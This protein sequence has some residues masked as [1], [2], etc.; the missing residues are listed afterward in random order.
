MAQK[1]DRSIK[2]F[3]LVECHKLVEANNPLSIGVALRDH[4][5]DLS[6]GDL[7]VEFLGGGHEVFGRDEALVI[8]IEILEDTLDILLSVRLARPLGHQLHEFLKGDL[9]AVVGVED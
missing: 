7:F 5:L 9:T 3:A 6:G 1:C 4:F 8:F 2:V